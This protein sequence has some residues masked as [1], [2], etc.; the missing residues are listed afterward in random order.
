M[1]APS[2]LQNV[3]PDQWASFL[4]PQW[5]PASQYDG[6]NWVPAQSAPQGQPPSGGVPVHPAISGAKY[7][8]PDRSGMV[9]KGSN[10]YVDSSGN[11]VQGINDAN[12]NQV[13]ASIVSQNHANAGGILGQLK[14]VATPFVLPAAAAIGVNYLL[15]A[16]MGGGA[17]GMAGAASS[18]TMGVD[19][20]AMGGTGA[21]GANFGGLLSGTGAA[22]DP[23]GIGAT[24]NGFGT[25][26]GTGLAD[27]GTGAA[28]TAGMAGTSTGIPALDNYFN[29]AGVNLGNSGGGLVNGLGSA[30]SAAS[31]LGS[32]AGTP[33][34]GV[35]TTPSGLGSA[36]G[37]VAGGA[38][39]SS[40]GGLGS[41]AGGLAAIGYADKLTGVDTSQGNQVFNSMSDLL[42]REQANSPLYVQAAQSPLLQSQAAGYG[43]LL[44]HL[45]QTGMLNSSFGANDIGNYMTNTNTGI[46]NAGIN[47]AQSAL[48]MQNS[49]LGQQ[50]NVANQI[51]NIKLGTQANKAN[52]IGR[53]LGGIGNG[54]NSSGGSL[55]SLGSN[56]Y[57][58]LG[59][60]GGGL[61]SIYN[62][63]FGS[64]G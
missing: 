8:S 29:N 6:T 39:G 20:A 3:S 25:S 62:N 14:D 32:G 60:L 23:Y 11:P 58:G 63:L 61:S 52:L 19:T 43:Q 26:A 31:G 27:L 51:A 17:A 64:G 4:A 40:L 50:G 21:T 35:G 28:T 54:L 38:A 24:I 2:N 18:G 15:P 1:Q 49:T 41:L 56:L 9:I 44:Q 16:L 48:G 42:G 47:A 53:A 36:A 59:S 46:A 5:I 45:G 33:T 7:Y 37:Q 34:P 13:G 10:G 12:I 30:G 57:S 22:A 55:G